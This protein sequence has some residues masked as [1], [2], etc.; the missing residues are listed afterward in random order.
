MR[1]WPLVLALVAGCTIQVQAPGTPGG[2]P[3]VKGSS[4]PAATAEPGSSP[5]PTG[6]LQ[7]LTPAPIPA[8]PSPRAFVP[9]PGPTIGPDDVVLTIKTSGGLCMYG[10]CESTTTF[11]ADGRYTRTQGPN[12][13]REGRV[14]SSL[15]AALNV[16]IDRTD[17]AAIKANKFTGTCPTAYDGQ[18]VTYTFGTPHGEEVIP[19]CTYEIPAEHPLFQAARALERASQANEAP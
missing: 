17:F 6:S 13:R 18:E 9:P 1:Y 12:D 2:S 19:G 7:P 11:R 10:L 4:K 3:A 15:S 8:S 16:E 14:D 5:R